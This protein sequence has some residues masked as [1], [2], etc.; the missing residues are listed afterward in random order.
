[1]ARQ[2]PDKK[3]RADP[4]EEAERDAETGRVEG[5]LAKLQSERDDLALR[6]AEAEK[7]IGELEARQAEVADR[8]RWA[9]DSVQT[10][11]ERLEPD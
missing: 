2:A 11:L 8:I 9:L 10:L 4:P 7:R 3:G 1:M 5:A 6:L